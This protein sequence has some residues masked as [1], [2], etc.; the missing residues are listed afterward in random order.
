MPL[1]PDQRSVLMNEGAFRGLRSLI[2]KGSLSEAAAR[3]VAGFTYK[4]ILEEVQEARKELMHLQTALAALENS[5]RQGTRN[6][7]ASAHDP[8]Y[9]QMTNHLITFDAWVVS[10]LE[11]DLTIAGLLNPTHTRSKITELAKAMNALMDKR[12]REQH[13]VLDDPSLF[14]GYVDR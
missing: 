8:V 6:P 4:A 9:D 2:T 13:P 11:T 14:R 5:A 12:A 3:Q 7:S 10:L 1:T